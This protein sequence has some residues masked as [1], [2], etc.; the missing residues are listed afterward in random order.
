MRV[1]FVFTNFN[2]SKFTRD[3]VKSISLN[4][5]FPESCV[6]V[7]DNRSDYK[8]V[9]ILKEILTD[10]PRIHVI[11]NNENLG[12]FKGLNKGI[13]Y[14]RDNYK[15]ICHMVIGNNDLIFPPEFIKSVMANVKVFENYPVISPDLVTLDGMHQNPHVIK[16]ISKFREFIYDVYYSSFL[17]AR[18]ITA[19]A[20]QTKKFTDRNDEREFKVAQT[21]WQGYGACYILGP[22]FFENFDQ[23]WAPSFLMGE[24]FFLSQQME[25]KNM[26]IFYD[27]DFVV[28]HQ[29]H[30]S[31]SKIPKKKLWEFSRESHEIYRKFVKSWR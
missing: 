31:V 14:L 20:K 7:V 2:N 13:R 28:I 12:Y 30:A 21:I 10:Y 15:D 6:V 16:K 26:K 24:E 3:A 23:L 22:L 4:D 29:E 27:P 17:M 19:M 11:F 9:E 18:F 1:G 5:F 8:E 25:N